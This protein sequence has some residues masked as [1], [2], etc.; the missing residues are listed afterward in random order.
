ME[1]CSFGD[2]DFANQPGA[3]S[4]L[5]E[6]EEEEEE[7][8]RRV[9]VHREDR[10]KENPISPPPRNTTTKTPENQ[11]KQTVARALPQQKLQSRSR[12]NSAILRLIILVNT[13]VVHYT[14]TITIAGHE[15]TFNARHKFSNQSTFNRSCCLSSF[16]NFS[17][18]LFLRLVREVTVLSSSSCFSNVSASALF[19][20]IFLTSSSGFLSRPLCLWPPVAVASRRSV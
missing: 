17:F 3:A 4:S 6:G 18:Y 16:R 5:R 13:R 7:E 15:T 14:T 20:S 12:I 9:I 1:P 11:A 8:Q 19:C 2:E 10:D